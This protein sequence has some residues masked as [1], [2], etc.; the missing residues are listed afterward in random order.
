MERRRLGRTG[1]E[2]SVAILGGAAFWD[3]TVDVVADAFAKAD[4]AGVNHLDIA[5]S[6]GKAE[7]LAGEVLPAYR[8]RWFVGCKTMARDRDGARKE[9]ERSLE[10]LHTDHFDI[11]QFHAVTS[12]DELAAAL[13][14]GGAVETFVAAREEGVVGALGLTGH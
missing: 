4:A 14:P 6:Y 10:L 13:A 5:P 2:S 7:Q 12:D 11:Y 9:L 3:T 8:D 1:H